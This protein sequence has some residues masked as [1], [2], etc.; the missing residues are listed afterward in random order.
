MR[1]LS[2]MIPLLLLSALPWAVS[3]Q[4]GV[5]EFQDLQWQVEETPQLYTYA[6]AKESCESLNHVSDSDAHSDTLWRLPNIKEIEELS[7]AHAAYTAQKPDFVKLSNE[8]YWSQTDYKNMD[9]SKLVLNFATGNNFWRLDD[10]RAY[11][12]CVKGEE[13]HLYQNVQTPHSVVEETP[14]Y[15]RFTTDG[16]DLTWHQAKNIPS[17]VYRD[18]KEYCENLPDG[19]GIMD[20]W[21]ETERS[22]APDVIHNRP[23][24]YFDLDIDKLSPREQSKLAYIAGVIPADANITLY[25]HTDRKQTV[26]YNIDLSQRRCATTA[27]MLVDLGIARERM[28]LVPRGESEPMIMTEDDRV[29]PRNRRVEIAFDIPYGGEERRVP[30]RLPTIEELHSLVYVNGGITLFDHPAMSDAYLQLWSSTP[31]VYERHKYWS[32]EVIQTQGLDYAINE[33]EKHHVICVR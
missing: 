27:S 18:A 3:A 12:L 6:Q 16:S 1:L 22:D 2:P 17:L 14:D 33:W 23:I 25:C 29:E 4:E 21:H 9:Y 15:V 28:T 32:M 7:Q 31:T 8:F 26:E 24:V 20:G 11:R 30:W 19:T 13:R 5:Y 10:D